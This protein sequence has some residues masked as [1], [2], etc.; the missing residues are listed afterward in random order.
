M[1]NVTEIVQRIRET[2]KEKGFSNARLMQASGLGVNYIKQMNIINLENITKI[3]NALDVSV[4]FLLYGYEKKPVP[5]DTEQDDSKMRLY[6]MLATMNSEDIQK[7]IDIVKLV[8][9]EKYN[10]FFNEDE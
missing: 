2:A 6:K 8:A 1:Y 4:D 7:T 9:P 3:A 10:K 5:E